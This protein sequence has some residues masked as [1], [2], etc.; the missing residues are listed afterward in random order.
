MPA[1]QNKAGVKLTLLLFHALSKSIKT[2]KKN[3][4]L[5]EKV[6]NKNILCFDM[7]FSDEKAQ[8]RSSAACSVVVC[9]MHFARSV[10]VNLIF[11]FQ[12]DYFSSFQSYSSQKEDKRAASVFFNV[13]N[14]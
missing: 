7:N 10:L 9:C 5:F 3:A 14:F 6:N 4:F 12:T 13:R 1:S 2:T 8:Q 11:F